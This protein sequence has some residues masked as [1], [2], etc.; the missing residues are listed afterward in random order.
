M[1]SFLK[2]VRRKRLSIHNDPANFDP[3]GDD[4]EQKVCPKTNQERTMLVEALKQHYVF[5]HLGSKDLDLVIDKMMKQ[6]FLKKGET[7]IEQGAVGDL[8]YVL[9]KGSA[10]ILVNGEKIGVYERPGDSFGEL[11]LL[12]SAKRAATI[13]TTEPRTEL[14]SLDAKSFHR[15][16]IKRTKQSTKGRVDFLK[17]VPLLQHV[18]PQLL[19]KVAD[20]LT[21]V[22]YVKNDRIINEGD[23]GDD[24]FLIHEGKVKCTHNDNDKKKEQLLLELGPGDYFGEMALM[25]D[26][27]RHANVEAVTPR[28]VCFKISRFDFVRLFGPLKDLLQQQMRIRILKSV[29]LL[30]D[31][32]D[33]VLDKVA[34]AMRIQNFKPKKN[35]IKQGDLGTRFYIINDGTARVSSVRRCEHG[36]VEEVLKTLGPQDFFGE[37]S[38]IND[39]PHAVTVTAETHLECL[40][41]DRDSF[42]AYL[43]DVDAVK[44]ERTRKAAAVS[45]QKSVLQVEESQKRPLPKDLQRWKTL[46][47][48]TFGRVSLVTHA[49]TH[50]VYALKQMQKTQILQSHQERNIMNEKNLLLLCNHP[51]VL[52]LVATYQDPDCLYML[53]ELVQGGELWSLIY[54]KTRETNHMRKKGFGGFDVPT[55]QFYLG[56]VTSAFDHI[57]GHGIA[58]RDLKP[59]NLLV[60][61][62]GYLKVIDFGFAK[63]V[64]W[65]D[66]K[67]G[68]YHDKS[69]TICGTP[70]YLCPEIIQSK[71][72]DKAVDY[73][74]LGCLVFE[75]LVGRTP[76]AD[77]RQPE[78][79]RKILNAKKFL[80]SDDKIWPKHFPTDAKHIVQNL[81][82]LEPPFRLGMSNK[83]IN[84]LKDHP[85]LSNVNFTSLLNKQLKAPYI[86]SINDPLDTS[87]FDPYDEHESITKFRGAQALFKDW[88]DMGA[89]FPAPKH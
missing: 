64:P 8:F 11:A 21:E 67:T 51:N 73:W 80:L 10:D 72:H 75:L 58:Y 29:P 20:A 37:K 52:A 62:Q 22:I 3:A 16:A 2:H 44:R 14:W 81:C 23:V 87:N 76:F 13:L 84:D 56:C 6:E 55:S 24:F 19:T 60:D 57:H 66:P 49:I 77:D 69:Y 4:Q 50:Q 25:L 26:E 63:Q 89:D 45:G 70:E 31:L 5:A 12:Y 65:T 34:D 38:L 15:L 48:G 71:G 47:T 27:P 7:V 85:F 68:V 61:A 46:G 36:D 83:G 18:N 86:P 82:T 17:K 41:L 79:F 40:V 54:E 30:R 78:I 1:T 74:A 88:S 39:E 42:R 43:A 32:T 35:I 33:D 28:V 59:E 53:M 9:N